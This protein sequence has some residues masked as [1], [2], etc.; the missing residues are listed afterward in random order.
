[1]SR[2]FVSRFSPRLCCAVLFLCPLFLLG[3]GGE[4]DFFQRRE[5]VKF[6]QLVDEYIDGYLQANPVLAT[7]MGIHQYDDAIGPVNRDQIF[8]ERKRLQDALQELNRIEVRFLSQDDKFDY[9]ILDY[10]IQSQLAN[11]DKIGYWARDPGYYD[12]L[13]C[14]GIDSL[15]HH[16][17]APVE[18]RLRS[19][20]AREEQIPAVLEASRDIID[21]IPRVLARIATDQFDSSLT[22]FREYLPQAFEGVQDAALLE[23][24][25]AANDGVIAA[26]EDY[27]EFLNDEVVGNLQY[28]YADFFLGKRNIEE[29]L[30]YDDFLEMSF[31]DILAYGHS[32]LERHQESLL[33]TAMEI[34]DQGDL[35]AILRDESNEGLSADQLF[36]TMEEAFEGARQFVADHDLV[37]LPSDQGPK[38]L[39]M[40]SFL[41][42]LRLVSLSVPGFQETT[43]ADAYLQLNLPDSGSNTRAIEAHM[44][45][46][47][48]SAVPLIA[49]HQSFPGR[50]LHALRRKDSPTKIRQV[51]QAPWTSEGWALYAEGMMLEEGYLEGDLRVQLERQRRQATAM[52]RLVAG[53]NLHTLQMN[54][55]EAVEFLMEEAYLDSAAA[56]R[57]ARRAVRKPMSVVAGI[58][59]RAIA[60][61]RADAEAQ[62]V[63]LKDFHDRLLT[64]GLPPGIHSLRT[65]SKPELRPP[66]TQSS[67]SR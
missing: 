38:P 29:K 10:H 44:R 51:L 56:E 26:Y 46:Y 42:P 31:D 1:M 4:D 16:G 8:G 37:T 58:R 54:F 63:G 30:L 2:E 33:Q 36:V 57:E 52:A 28:R 24:F 64:E 43:A 59:Q 48:S 45:S 55:E 7:E 39:E 20:I 62:G 61:L 32:E 67:S 27:L 53:M 11:F 17:T 12:D 66:R 40:S 21:N 35:A 3:C 22:Y 14:R 6:T 25:Q 23:E 13:I 41:R 5:A 18:T 9:Q 47:N 50:Y 19:I 49:I 34:D 65:W 60:Q 15:L